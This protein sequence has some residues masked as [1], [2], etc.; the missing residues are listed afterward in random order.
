MIIKETLK[1]LV[2]NDFR[3]PKIIPIIKKIVENFD[4]DQIFYML[5]NG[6]KISD[7]LV[8]FYYVGQGFRCMNENAHIVGVKPICGVIERRLNNNL[9]KSY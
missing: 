5:Q 3:E 8:L 6:I 1:I 4:D 9:I 2:E 7:E